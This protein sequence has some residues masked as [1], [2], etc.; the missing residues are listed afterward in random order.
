MSEIPVNSRLLGL[1][2]LHVHVE[3]S[4]GEGRPV[5]LIHGWPLSGASWKV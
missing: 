2:E 4:G 3:D 5:L 1:K